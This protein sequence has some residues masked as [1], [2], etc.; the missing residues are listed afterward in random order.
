MILASQKVADFNYNLSPQQHTTKE[1]CLQP[2]FGAGRILN[3]TYAQRPKLPPRTTLAGG[4]L[5]ATCKNGTA[6]G[7]RMPFTK[8]TTDSIGGL[9]FISSQEKVSNIYNPWGVP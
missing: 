9:F 6:V 8:T 5:T 1:F 2:L 3:R 4:I 7:H